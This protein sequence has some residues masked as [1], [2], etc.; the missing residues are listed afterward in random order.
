MGEIGENLILCVGGLFGSIFM[1]IYLAD[2]INLET[3][4][5]LGFPTL[6][7]VTTIHHFFDKRGYLTK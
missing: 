4:V 2:Y 5:A 1:T 6:L 3:V 7:L